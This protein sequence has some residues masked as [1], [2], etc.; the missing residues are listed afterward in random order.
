MCTNT[1]E[2]TFKPQE[3]Q[4]SARISNATERTSALDTHQVKNGLL[5]YDLVG[6]PPPL[7]LSL[8]SIS[9]MLTRDWRSSAGGGEPPAESV[10]RKAASGQ[11]TADSG[12][13]PRVLAGEG[14]QI[15]PFRARAGR[16]RCV[17]CPYRVGGAAGDQRKGSRAGDQQHRRAL[18]Q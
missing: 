1:L 3:Y 5:N 7:P 16:R 13:W 4:E 12:Q 2:R 17:D 15:R 6:K 18:S 10:Q 14:R 8:S 9:P 11:R